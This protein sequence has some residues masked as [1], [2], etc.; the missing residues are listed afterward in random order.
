MFVATSPH[1]A[2]AAANPRNSF[3]VTIGNFDGVHIG[4]RALIRQTTDQAKKNDLLSLALTFDPHPAA[5]LSPCAPPA[6]G[7]MAQRLNIFQTLGIDI[8][9]V[10]P[11]TPEFA[12]LTAADFCRKVLAGLHTK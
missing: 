4:H 3:A 11:F 10:L 12:A 7:D 1:A 5:V 2:L 8:T 6:L 9:L